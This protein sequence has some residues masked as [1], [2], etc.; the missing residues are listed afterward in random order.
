MTL[1]QD[2][3]KELLQCRSEIVATMSQKNITA[4]G[5]TAASMEVVQDSNGVRLILR[6]TEHAPLETLEV[7]R[8]G[9]KMPRNATDI[10]M[11]WSKDKGLNW[12]DD[13][14]RRRIAGAV[15]WG[16]IRKYGTG[17]HS[18]PTEVYSIPVKNAQDN[19]RK[20]IRAAVTQTMYQAAKT[21][22]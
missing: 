17:R 16:K 7:G 13:K 14:A 1:A 21:N 5:R 20:D 22:F 2:I 11:Q 18:H 12:G 15:A 3:Q 6:G 10:V 8:P 19:I 4:S 9:G